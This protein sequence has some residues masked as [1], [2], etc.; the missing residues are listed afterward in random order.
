MIGPPVS[1]VPVAIL[2]TVPAGSSPEGIKVHALPFEMRVSPAFA[3]I[4]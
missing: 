4:D 2:V 3:A 1:P